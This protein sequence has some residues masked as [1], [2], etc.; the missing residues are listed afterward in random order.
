MDLM[1]KT[2]FV[3]CN[4]AIFRQSNPICFKN[5]WKFEN[6]FI[7]CKNTWWSASNIAVKLLRT[8]VRGDFNIHG[9]K[10]FQYPV[11]G[12]YILQKIRNYANLKI[13]SGKTL[14]KLNIGIYSKFGQCYRYDMAMYDFIHIIQFLIPIWSWIFQNLLIVAIDWPK[15]HQIL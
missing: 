9:T 7:F 12:V 14:P 15:T 6:L 8:E 2:F 5:F 3:I 4:F 11:S 13:Q 10:N 1:N